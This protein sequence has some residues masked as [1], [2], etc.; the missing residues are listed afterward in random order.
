MICISGIY[1]SL[2]SCPVLQSTAVIIT[3]PYFCSKFTQLLEVTRIFLTE[4][5]ILSAIHLSFGGP[6][7]LSTGRNTVQ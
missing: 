1:S 2:F 4:Q 7:V 6:E 3:L 5:S